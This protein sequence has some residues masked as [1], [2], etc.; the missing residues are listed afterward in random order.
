MKAI[1]VTL[2]VLVA[3]PAGASTVQTYDLRL[4][5]TG[6]ESF[7]DL[8]YCSSETCFSSPPED[9]EAGPMGAFSY[10]SP[11]DEIR[12][13]ATTEKFGD[14]EMPVGAASG[15]VIGGYDCG[16]ETAY[17]MRNDPDTFS[18]WLDLSKG[19]FLFLGETALGSEVE[20]GVLDRPFYAEDDRYAVSY[21]DYYARFTV[22]P[23]PLPAGAFLLGGGLALLVAAGWFRRKAVWRS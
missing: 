15:C 13:V 6:V 17:A 16:G 5:F 18:F 22:V 3:A 4:E 7:G 20:I 2:A 10:L 21:S 1:L 19:S 23:V 11:G 9:A 8:T 12:F 14:D